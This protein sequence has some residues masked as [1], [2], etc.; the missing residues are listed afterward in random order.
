MGDYV[1]VLVEEL[2]NSDFAAGKV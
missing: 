1:F 2:Q